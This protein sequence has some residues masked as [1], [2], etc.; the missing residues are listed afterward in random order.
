MKYKLFI[1][2]ITFSILF[3]SCATHVHTIG[4]GAQTGEKITARQFYL[5]YGLIPLNSVDTNN[6]AGFDQVGNFNTNYEIKTQWSLIDAGLAI[7][8]GSFTY[9]LAPIVIQSRTVTITK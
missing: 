6:M 9:G 7:A 4:N 8:L 2:T 5:F 1:L 3:I